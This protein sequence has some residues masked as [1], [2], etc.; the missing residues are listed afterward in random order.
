MN[1]NFR[2]TKGNGTVKIDGTQISNCSFFGFKTAL[3]NASAKIKGIIVTDDKGTEL[4]DSE[5]MAVLG[6]DVETDIP[7]SYGEI[8]FPLGYTITFINTTGVFILF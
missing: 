1:E 3:P 6:L 7:Y 4:T 8:M 2:N 5:A